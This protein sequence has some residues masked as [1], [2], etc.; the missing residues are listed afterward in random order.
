MRVQIDKIDLVLVI[1]NIVLTVLIIFL[2][3]W[4]ARFAFGQSWLTRQYTELDGMGSSHVNDIMQDHMGRIWMA[5]RAGIDRYDGLNWRNYSTADGLPAMG[6][7]KIAVDREG[8]IWAIPEPYSAGCLTAFFFDGDRWNR[9]ESIDTDTRDQHKISAFQLLEKEGA[10]TPVLLVSSIRSGLYRWEKGSWTRFST[11]NG[12]PDNTVNCIQLWKG[13]HYAATGGGLSRLNGD[14]FVHTPRVPLPGFPST[15]IKGIHP[16]GERLWLFSDGY[17]GY[18]DNDAQKTVYFQTGFVFRDKLKPVRLLPDGRTGMYIAN[19]YEIYY[20]D[21]RTRKAEVIGIPNGLISAGTNSI[22]R[23]F[24]GNIWVACGRGATKISSRRF[25]NY[26]KQAGLLEDEVTAILEYQPGKFV[27][28][29]NKGLTFW[30][31]D[32]FRQIHFAGK[33]G[34]RFSL[35]RV[36]DMKADSKQNIWLALSETGPAKIDKQYNFTWYGTENGAPGRVMCLWIDKRDRV[37]M[38]SG[39]DIYFFEKNKK[40]PA[41][42]RFDEIKP[43]SP[44]RKIYGEG[45]RL[46]YLTSDGHGIYAYDNKNK[47][48]EN[49]RVPGRSRGN[50]TYAVKKDSKGRLL[51]GTAAGLFFAE[52]GILKR[53][54]ENEFQVRRPIYFITEDTHRRIWCGTNNGMIRWDGKRKISYSIPEGL[55]GQE[56]NRAANCVDS[57][58][59][60]WI[61]TNNGLSV[62]DEVFDNLDKT[63]L[64]PKLHLLTLGVE[65]RKI[66]LTPSDRPIELSYKEDTV[67]FHFRGIS[68]LD[69]SAIRFSHKLEGVDNDWLD[70][71]YPYNQAI[72]YSRLNPGTYRFFLKARNSLGSWSEPAVSAKIIVSKPFYQKWW[73]FLLMV[74][75]FGAILY[76]VFYF[77][78]AKRSAG[79]LEKLVEER[80]G[81][82]NASEK[83]YRALFEESRDMIFTTTSAGKFADLNPACVELLGYASKEDA[84]KIDIRTK[85]LSSRENRVKFFNE[86]KEKGYVKDFEL[87]MQRKD[88]EKIV[89]LITATPIPGEKGDFPAIR[90]IA[91]DITEKKRLQEQL[92]QAQ[93]MEAIGTLA[94]GIAHDFNNILSVITGYIEL[95]FDDLPEGTQLRR[96]IDQVSIAARRAKELVARILTFSRRDSHERK[97][98]EIAAIVKEALKLLRSSL[99]ATIDIRRDISAEPVIVLADATQIQQVVMNLCTNAAHAMREKG[100]VLEAKLHEIYLDESAAADYDDL[101]PGTYLK[102]SVRDTGHGI[103]PAIAKRIFEPYFTTKKKG[104]GTGMGL[105]VIHGIVKSHGGDITVESTPGKGTAF[106]VLLPVVEKTVEPRTEKQGPTPGGKREHILFVDDEKLL[107]EVTQKTLEKLG[108][109]VTAKNN[110]P[111]ALEAFTQNPGDFDLVLTDYT[112]PDMTGIQLAKKILALRP[113]IPVIICTGYS[114]AV[115]PEQMTETGIHSLLTKP[116]TKPMLARAIRKALEKD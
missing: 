2:L 79:L 94:G 51:V 72:R 22:S 23:D 96:N 78:A 13:D 73:F 113:D 81:Q 87:H 5:T 41:F 92:Q 49:I 59:K 93:K 16:D 3:S 54:K 29:H 18:L 25:T 89:T 46:R 75:A 47:R 84:Q 60:L 24:E 66:P 115:S 1:R 109:R 19:M 8:R 10:E 20:Y 97:P 106:H 9:I 58:G 82:L 56:T 114:E 40:G 74:L 11:K 32:R 103:A 37:W 88:G 116:M 50:S 38:G 64:P 17:L 90:S 48:W 55:I 71:H 35:C 30:D 57:T 53:F 31:G 6:F 4:P 39:K 7:V 101:R 95:S 36:L 42:S 65:N 83:R 76:A 45:T 21:F 110:S 62:Y 12:L 104:E 43:A 61:G 15:D 26:Q 14:G 100:G 86:L 77:Y 44:L 68:F 52:N 34:D 105:A 111:D 107:V 108:Y 102:L 33:V 91:R 80:T 98:L 112:M 99:P 63:I 85:L 27:L 67:V 70:E 69:E 28:G